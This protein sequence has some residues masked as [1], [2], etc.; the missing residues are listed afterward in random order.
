MLRHRVGD[1]RLDLGAKLEDLEFLLEERGESL[2]AGP[3]I[4]HFEEL[5]FFG[6]REIEVRGDEIGELA[7]V[8]HVEGRDLQLFGEVGREG[9]HLG[10]GLGGVAGEGLHL[11]VGRD[12]ILHR[13]D[14]GTKERGPFLKVSDSCAADALDEHAGAVVGKLEHL[15]HARDTA[16]LMEVL[17]L[18]V[19]LLGLL[20]QDKEEEA[21]A[22]D[23]LVHKVNGGLRVDEEGRHHEG[24]HHHIT[25]RH[26]GQGGR[27][28]VL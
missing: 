28:G 4:G 7:G 12:F 18:G 20:L 10:E 8:L 25:E 14:R 21:I 1:L 26:D 16:E 22:G 9:D 24:E 27:Q 19:F 2:E 6:R 3:C 15:E 11:D 23:H 5:L 17:R 13:L